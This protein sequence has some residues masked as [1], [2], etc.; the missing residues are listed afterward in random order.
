MIQRSWCG[1]HASFLAYTW[2]VPR[3]NS[4]YSSSPMA[5]LVTRRGSWE[6]DLWPVDLT[7]CVTTRNRRPGK[8][9]MILFL[10]N[11]SSAEPWFETFY[12]SSF[13]TADL[14]EI[15]TSLQFF[16]WLDRSVVKCNIAFVIEDFSIIRGTH[17]SCPVHFR[18]SQKYGISAK[19]QH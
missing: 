13:E 14:L 16:E 1:E 10:G 4:S 7:S 12:S 5:F 19:A 8:G 18:F 6:A 2:N 11:L 15:R 3:G 17:P 9:A